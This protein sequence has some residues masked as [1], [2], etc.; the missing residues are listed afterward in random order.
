MF[1]LLPESLK[2]EIKKE[3]HLRRA[4][5][6]FAFLVFIG[7]TFLIFLF[8]SWIISFYKEKQISQ[9][10]EQNNQASLLTEVGEVNTN[11]K[12]INLELQTINASLEYKK[13]IP[14]INSVLL[15]KTRSITL[16]EITYN[17]SD[18]QNSTILI[19]GV[20]STRNSLL[21]FVKSL[22]DSQAFKKVD[23]PISNFAKDRNIN[24]S[25]SLTIAPK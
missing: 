10:A 12:N 21:A 6:V 2:T 23:L 11:I 9:Q 17:S 8:P 5:V 24:F 16:N 13:I 14:F 19:E 7:G 22:E 25:I 1:N 4:V 20:S 3:Y 15:K 18:P